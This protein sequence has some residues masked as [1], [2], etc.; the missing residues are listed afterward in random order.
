MLLEI[1]NQLE[2][3]LSSVLGEYVF[4]DGVITPA[5]AVLPSDFWGYHYPP[6]QTKVSGIELTIKQAIPTT[7]Q[8]LS[9]E[10]LERINYDIHLKQWDRV[11]EL[12]TATQLLIECLQGNGYLFT[13]P[14][15]ISP[16][17]NN[18]ISVFLQVYSF[19]VI[20]IL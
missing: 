4:P 7:N 3:G 5:I 15:L 11:G 16:S 9:S 6:Q 19:S 1:R 10:T 18:V 2:A 12:N 8:L 13:S 20:S 17:S 14:E